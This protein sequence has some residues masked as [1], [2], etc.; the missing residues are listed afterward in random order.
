MATVDEARD[1]QNTPLNAALVGG[2]DTLSYQ[3]EITFTKYVRLVLPLDGF[4]FWIKADLLSQSALLNAATFNGAAFNQNE[5]VITP[6]ATATIKGSFHYETQSFQDQTET[7]A[8]NRVIFT[9]EAEIQDFNEIGPNVIFIGMFD[10]IRFAFSSRGSFYRQADIFHYVGHAV[11]SIMDSQIVDSPD[12]LTSKE[13]IVSNSLPIWLSMNSYQKLEV[14]NFA[15]PDFP[16]YPSFSSPQNM[17]PPYATVHI[18]PTTTQGIQGAPFLASTLSHYQLCQETVRIVFYGVRNDDVLNFM[19]FVNQFSSNYDSI[20]LMNIPVVQDDKRT[21]NEFNILAMRKTAEFQ[22]NYY[23]T[24]LRDVARQLILE[25]IPSYY[26]GVN[27][28]A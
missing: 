10:G 8:N 28:I 18:E 26:V 23:Q 2:I 5:T 4:V 24:S 3:Q 7:Y 1:G 19:D 17:P 14:E 22:I 13:L 15:P 11:Y 21:Q 25:A 9:A 12:G 6:A 27:K 20:G 16:L